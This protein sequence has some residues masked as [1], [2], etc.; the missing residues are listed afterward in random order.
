MAD[1]VTSIT[2]DD[3]I[4]ALAALLEPL[5][6]GYTI[7]RGQVNRVPQ[8]RPLAIILTEVHLA[9]LQV[10][11]YFVDPDAEQGAIHGP[12]QIGVQCD[13]YGANA[14]DVCTVIKQALRSDYAF[15]NMPAAIKVLYPDDGRQIPLVT[16]EQQYET[17][18]TLTVALQYNPVVTVPQQTATALEVDHLVAADLLPETP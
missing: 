3:V 7:V 2:V 6:A 1:F 11:S 10:P 17:R 15:R 16:G 12:R 8:P 13:I 18:W 5:A 9:D 4:D 14:G